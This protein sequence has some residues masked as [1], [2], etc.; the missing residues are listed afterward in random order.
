MSRV[1][2]CMQFGYC[3]SEISLLLPPPLLTLM[4]GGK[5]GEAPDASPASSKGKA[6]LPGA[7]TLLPLPLLPH[8]LLLGQEYPSCCSVHQFSDASPL[9]KHPLADTLAHGAPVS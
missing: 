8:L 6:G 3:G 7:L 4:L 2:G 9:R 1:L 5:A